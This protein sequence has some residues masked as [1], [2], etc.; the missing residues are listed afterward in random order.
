M[1]WI[2]FNKA[3]SVTLKQAVSD[4]NRASLGAHEIPDAFA[5][6]LPDLGEACGN[7][8]GEDL[9]NIAFIQ[10][11]SK[12]LQVGAQQYELHF[13]GHALQQLPLFTQGN[14][15]QVKALQRLQ[16]IKMYLA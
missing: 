12:K 3:D 8:Y 16:L 9:L 7:M 6:R 4:V 1:H 11:L 14:D 5:A 13:P 2:L 10:G 15:E